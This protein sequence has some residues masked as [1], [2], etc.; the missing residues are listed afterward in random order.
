[1]PGLKLAFDEGSASAESVIQPDH[2]GINSLIAEFEVATQD[3]EV[4]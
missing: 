3:R 4:G 2:D 1:M